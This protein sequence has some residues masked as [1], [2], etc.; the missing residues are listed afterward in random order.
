MEYKWR[1]L[2]SYCTPP[3]LFAASKEDVFVGTRV[4]V[5]HPL[6][7]NSLILD[8]AFKFCK[9]IRLCSNFL[10]FSLSMRN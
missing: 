3:L 2:E 7:K 1:P 5:E 8:A 9:N 4:W 10:R 6:E